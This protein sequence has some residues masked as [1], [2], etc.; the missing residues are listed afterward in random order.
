MSRLISSDSSRR[1]GISRPS[2]VVPVP[3]SGARWI[4]FVSQLS[5]PAGSGLRAAQPGARVHESTTSRTSAGTSNCC[6]GSASEV[7]GASATAAA[8]WS[9]WRVA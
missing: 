1:T 3:T 5:V 7:H 9:P 2:K 4:C 8:R 6:S